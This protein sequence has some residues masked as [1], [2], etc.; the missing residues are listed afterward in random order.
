MQIFQMYRKCL[1]FLGA[2]SCDMKQGSH[3]GPK[4]IRCQGTSFSH[5]GFV[6]LWS[7]QII[8]ISYLWQECFYIAQF[9]TRTS[10]LFMFIISTYK[11][12]W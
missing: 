5:L 8:Y 2:T 3:K 9:V 7:K 10:I 12:I 4:N 1:K 11:E 6:L